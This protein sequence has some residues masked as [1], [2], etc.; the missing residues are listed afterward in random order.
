VRRDRPKINARITVWAG[1]Q[2]HP[3]VLRGRVRTDWGHLHVST[4]MGNLTF[5]IED[6]GKTWVRG[7]NNLEARVLEATVLLAGSAG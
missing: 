6:E 4:P 3:I 5:D 2:R 7:W 1:G